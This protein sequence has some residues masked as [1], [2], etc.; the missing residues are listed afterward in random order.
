MVGQGATGAPCDTVGHFSRSAR[1]VHVRNLVS[2]SLSTAFSFSIPLLIFLYFYT[3]LR[4]LSR[5]RRS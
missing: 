4:R 1:R 3:V 2:R 5:V